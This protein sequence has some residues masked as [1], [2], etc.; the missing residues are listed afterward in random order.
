MRKS[1]GCKLCILIFYTSTLLAS[2]NLQAENTDVPVKSNSSINDSVEEGW[3]EKKIAPSTKWIE[4][5]FSPFTQWIE[6]EIHQESN[7]QIR[8][9]KTPSNPQIITAQ[10]ATNSVLE[11]FPGKILR[12]QFQTGPPPHYKIKLLSD[13]GTVSVFT[14]HA[15]SGQ[16]FTLPKIPINMNEAKQ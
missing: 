5:I 1:R 11:K 4:S 6:R 7:S 10:H 12:N 8:P 16:L 15:F 14:V 2:Y 9:T 3:V 13:N